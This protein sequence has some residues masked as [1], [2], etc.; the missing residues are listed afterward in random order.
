M[1]DDLD[2]VVKGWVPLNPPKPTVPQKIQNSFSSI[3][4]GI[5]GVIKRVHKNYIMPST[6]SVLKKLGFK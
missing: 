3:G 2:I 1:F 6:Y 5:K 4:E